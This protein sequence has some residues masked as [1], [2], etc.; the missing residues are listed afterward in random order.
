MGPKER[1]QKIAS[2]FRK[3]KAFRVE[4]PVCVRAGFS[5]AREHYSIFML[6]RAA[7]S[8]S[9]EEYEIQVLVPFSDGSRSPGANTRVYG[10]HPTMVRE[11]RDAAVSIG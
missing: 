1:A 6:F 3:T 9:D 8:S 4:A 5:N 11:I 10:D 7:G 2:F